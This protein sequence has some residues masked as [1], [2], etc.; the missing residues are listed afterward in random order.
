MKQLVEANPRQVSHELAAVLGLS[1]R[2]VIN[3]LHAIDKVNKLDQWVPHDLSDWDHRRRVEAA[4]SLLSYKRTTAWLDSIVTGD[5]KCVLHINIKRRKSWID[6]GSVPQ[7]Q[8]KAPRDPHKVML[9][10]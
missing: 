9:C 2:T 5:E 6:T 3:H 8:L 7:R 10:V 4:V 1:Y